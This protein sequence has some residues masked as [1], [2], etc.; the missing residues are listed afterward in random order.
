MSLNILNQKSG[1]GKVFMLNKP[2]SLYPVKR[3]YDSFKDN[4][5]SSSNW[6]IDKK[7]NDSKTQFIS[8]R[9]KIIAGPAFSNYYHLTSNVHYISVL[10]CPKFRAKLQLNSLTNIC[11]M[12]GLY[13]NSD[14]YIAFMYDP[15]A[16][17]STWYT[18]TKSKGIST[19]ND[20]MLIAD[21]DLHIFEISCSTNKMITFKN[22]HTILS[23]HRTYIPTK[24]M[25]IFI[26]LENNTKQDASLILHHFDL[27]YKI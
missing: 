15:G 21:K 2:K 14:N 20:T 6:T 23:E 19:I 24:D 8:K 4:K 27:Q 9:L 16:E 5:I 12:F 11:L 10:K 3:F 13:Y 25:K 26:K 17:I 22:L 1:S 18:I 7:G